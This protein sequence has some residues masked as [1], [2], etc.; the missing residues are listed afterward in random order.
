M[1]YVADDGAVFNTEKECLEY[2][3]KSKF[4]Q[5]RFILYSETFD[6]LDMLSIQEWK[7]VAYVYV[8]T[9]DSEAV[10]YLSDHSWLNTQDIYVPGV[11]KVDA[12]GVCLNLDDMIHEH[13]QIVKELERERN[14]IYK[15]IGVPVIEEDAK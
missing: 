7:D 2:E 11:Y 6:V 13:A 5:S 15:N 12:I 10:S 14:V 1:K 3:T 9:Y 4:Y 8:R